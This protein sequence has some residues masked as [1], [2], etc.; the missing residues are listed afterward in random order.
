MGKWRSFTHFTLLLLT[1]IEEF[2]MARPCDTGMCNPSKCPD[3]DHCCYE[4][5]SYEEPKLREIVPYQASKITHISYEKVVT[6]F[7]LRE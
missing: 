7:S 5:P 4:P 1:F 2:I 6:T 3:V